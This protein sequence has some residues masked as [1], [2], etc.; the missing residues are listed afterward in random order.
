MV[1]TLIGIEEKPQDKKNPV[2][3]Y[4]KFSFVITYILLLT[5]ATITFIE[6]MRTNIPHV[7]HI[8]NLE[9]AISVIA[10]YFYSVFVQ[11]I[12]KCSSDSKPIN[13]E[14][15]TKTR[16]IDWSI[17]TPLM[18][19]ALCIV[20]GSHIGVKVK[21]P[22]IGSIIAFNYFMLYSGY[23]GEIGTWSR[24]ISLIIGFAAFFAVFAII[25]MVFVKPKFVWANYVL[26][27]IYLFLWSLYGVVYMFGEEYK[28]IAT[29]VLD[30]TA[31]CFVGLGL[32]A[33]FTRI[34]S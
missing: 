26:Y 8:L 4:V 17:T 24:S 12:E 28:N 34:I 19:L 29:N 11:Q 13:W 1:E 20:L 18:L 2:Q 25:F 15:I 32:W 3:Y 33:Y 30:F 9:T 23:L 5:T 21:L 22:V 27:G 6:A 10:G 7:R 14:D 31:K 16:Y